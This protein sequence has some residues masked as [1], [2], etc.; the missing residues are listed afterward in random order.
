[1]YIISVEPAGPIATV[2]IDFDAALETCRELETG[3]V[4]WVR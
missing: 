4:N 2:I 1:M 3:P